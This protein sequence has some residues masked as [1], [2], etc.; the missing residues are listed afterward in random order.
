MK[1][2]KF[3]PVLVLILAFAI[4]APAGAMTNPQDN[5][6]EIRRWVDDHPWGGDAYSP[7][8]VPDR[9]AAPVGFIDMPFIY[10][11]IYNII[12]ITDFQ[13]VS[14]SDQ[15]DNILP[16]DYSDSDNNNS[17]LPTRGN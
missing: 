11:D 8:S 3:V 1:Q 2:L 9:S 6:Q 7:H 10:I 16:E 17:N 15:N 14:D 5:E 13:K 4:I 12:V